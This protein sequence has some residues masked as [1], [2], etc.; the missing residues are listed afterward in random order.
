[1]VLVVE[2]L[3][4]KTLDLIPDADFSPYFDEYINT[5]LMLAKE[6]EGMVAAR[7]VKI[8]LGPDGKVFVSLNHNNMLDS[9]IYYIMF[10]DGTVNN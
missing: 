4:V 5:E 10:M 7:V 2:E 9:R 6:G 8:S 1:M 3:A